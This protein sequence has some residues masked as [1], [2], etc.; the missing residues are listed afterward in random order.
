MR[1]WVTRPEPDATV[2]RARLMAQGHDVV[3]EPLM[4]ID[5]EDVDP[6]ELD[7]AQAL[8]ATSRNGVRAA[9]QSPDAE[10]AKGLPL[11]AVGPGTAAT[12][13]GLGFTDVIEGPATASGLA[14]LISDRVEVNGGA[15]VHLAG[16]A[17][18]HDMAGDLRRLGYVVLQPT[19][20]TA[21]LAKRL[22][23]G[24]LPKLVMGE[25]DAVILLSARTAQTYVE[26]IQAH[27][28]VRSSRKLE[29][30]CLSQAVADRLAPLQL[31]V[32]KVPNRPNIQE[33]LALTD[34]SAA[35]SR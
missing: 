2:L 4:W 17:L 24:F 19:V 23:G 15:L 34:Q 3:I 20:Y 6:V 12:A 9:A 1:I 35:Q 28:L 21:R 11:Y 14:T 26:L 5:F 7:D 25:I 18:A 22:S 10:F 13:K 16:A 27:Q 33:I 30:Y 31:T 32:I 8:I 29:Y